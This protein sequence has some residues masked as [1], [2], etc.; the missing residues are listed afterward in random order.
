[1]I[2]SP[3]NSLFLCRIMRRIFF[4][5]IWVQKI[6]LSIKKIALRLHQPAVRWIKKKNL[7][8]SLF[9]MSIFFLFFKSLISTFIFM[10]FL[11][12]IFSIFWFFFLLLQ[13]LYRICKIYYYLLFIFHPFPPPPRPLFWQ[14]QSLFH[15]RFRI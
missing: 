15:F 13:W 7:W 2:L 9:I 8:W 11:I 5:C 6:V 12:K 4:R 10:S 3:G 1:M 14:P